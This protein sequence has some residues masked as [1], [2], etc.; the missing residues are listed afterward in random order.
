M[1]AAIVAPNPP[2]RAH[3]LPAPEQLNP[4]VYSLPLAPSVA[5]VA[6]ASAAAVP[7]PAASAS[8]FMDWL[9]EE[10]YLAGV[11]NGLLAA[12]G[13]FVLALIFGGG[14]KRR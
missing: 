4:A 5:Q 12:G 8:S 3:I 2:N 9:S 14:K 1:I 10:T 11:P 7:A 6:A 13:V